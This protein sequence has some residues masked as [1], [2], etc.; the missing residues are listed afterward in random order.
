VKVVFWELAY[1]LKIKY[2]L[3]LRTLII[4]IVFL[5]NINVEHQLILTVA[6]IFGYN[7][8]FKIYIIW[9]KHNIH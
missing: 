3:L 9:T 5:S 8:Y 6:L 2:F 1:I 4:E 7:I